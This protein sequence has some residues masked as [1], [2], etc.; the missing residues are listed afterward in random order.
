MS[1]HS[2][3]G[4]YRPMTPAPVPSPKIDWHDARSEYDQSVADLLAHRQRYQIAQ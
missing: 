4:A 2:N 1:A 3:V